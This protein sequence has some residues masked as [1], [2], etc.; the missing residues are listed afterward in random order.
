MWD[1]VA[2]AT[3]RFGHGCPTEKYGRNRDFLK[4][5]E[6]EEKIEKM[7]KESELKRREKGENGEIW[8][9]KFAAH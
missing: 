1:S 5:G 7:N 9:L 6:A 4:F 2:D 3:R 8:I